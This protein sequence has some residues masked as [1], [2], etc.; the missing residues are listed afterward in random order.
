MELK[1]LSGLHRDA[2]THRRDS[3]DCRVWPRS[4]C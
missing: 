3:V 1:D 4:S 2:V